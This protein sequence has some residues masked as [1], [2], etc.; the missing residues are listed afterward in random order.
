MIRILESKQ[1]GRLL[2]RK[3]AR[4]TEAEAVVRPILE[5]VRQRGDRALLEYARQFDRLERKSVRVPE[6]ELAR[7]ARGADAGIPRRRRDRRR[8]HPRLRRAPDAARVDRADSSPA[9]SSDRSCARSIP[10]R[11]TSRRA[12]I[13]CPP[14]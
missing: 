9:C 2:A 10:W 1:V 12:A 5:A 4:F 13:R 14:P 11:P 6:P 8:Q 7:R 3:A